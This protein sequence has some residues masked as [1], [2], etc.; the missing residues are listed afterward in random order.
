MISPRIFNDNTRL[1]IS[2]KN[3]N[4]AKGDIVI[5]I[6][7]F[8]D[9]YLDIENNYQY[10]FKKLLARNFYTIPFRLLNTNV[11][12]F[13]FQGFLHLVQRSFEYLKNFTDKI[14]ITNRS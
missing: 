5:N 13:G 1:L 6:E 12:Y 2:G 11:I 7:A 9:L 10:Q 8:R 14:Y 4:F 3:I